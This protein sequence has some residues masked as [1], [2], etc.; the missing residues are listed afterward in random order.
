MG[1][2][3]RLSQRRLSTSSTS[4]F[5]NNSGSS[6]QQQQQVEKG[7]SHS[8]SNGNGNG[9]G[10][11]YKCTVEVAA[12]AAPS[13]PRN[14]INERP[15]RRN[16]YESNCMVPHLLSPTSIATPSTSRKMLKTFQD[17]TSSTV[18]CSSLIHL[19]LRGLPKDCKG[20]S[21]CFDLFEVGKTV[22]YL[23]CGHLYHSSC[24][25]RELKHSGSCPTCGY[26]LPKMA[27]AS[28]SSSTVPKKTAGRRRSSAQRSKLET[29]LP[30]VEGG[31]DDRETATSCSPRPRS[32]GSDFPTMLTIETPGPVMPNLCDDSSCTSSS[33]PNHDEQNEGVETSST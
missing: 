7:S 8:R 31:D 2:L 15:A 32:S 24:L 27:T 5:K 1:L 11:P 10:L 13:T 22:T 9:N 26:E 18:D 33:T 12:A 20:C 14:S 3:K 29:T 19:R 28:P 23:P 4:S 16:S 17:A 25:I 21:V 6:H 30:A